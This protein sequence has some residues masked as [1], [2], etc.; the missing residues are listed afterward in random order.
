MVAKNKTKKDVTKA[1]LIRVITQKTDKI[2][3]RFQPMV[4]RS[5]LNGLKYKTKP[6]LKRIASKIKVEVDSTGYDIH[7]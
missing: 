4:R 7:T 5:F 3:T 6:E 1:E 2:P